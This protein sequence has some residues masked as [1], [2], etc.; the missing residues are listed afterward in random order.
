M[1]VHVLPR[2]DGDRL[3]PHTGQMADMAMLEQ[4]AQK[5]RV[6]LAATHSN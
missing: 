1:H 6:A 4:Q 5:I 2:H 3:K